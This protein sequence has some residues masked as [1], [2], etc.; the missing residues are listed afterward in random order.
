MP[1]HWHG[2][3]R[4]HRPAEPEEL[5]SQGLLIQPPLSESAQAE[6]CVALTAVGQHR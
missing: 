2:Q 3:E 4:A 6:Y 5:S 1:I